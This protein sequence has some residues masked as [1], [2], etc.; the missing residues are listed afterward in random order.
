MNSGLGA[1]AQAYR[2]NLLREVGS[3]HNGQLTSAH[4][5]I[6]QRRLQLLVVRLDPLRVGPEVTGLRDLNPE[7]VRLAILPKI[8]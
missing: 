3:H 4:L 2:Q 1:L 5:E 8:Q 6:R 7:S